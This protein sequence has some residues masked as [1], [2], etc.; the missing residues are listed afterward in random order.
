MKKLILTTFVL[1]ALYLLFRNAEPYQRATAAIV[2]K[3]AR[4][5]SALTTGKAE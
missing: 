3:F 1:I 5:W 2:A 4:A